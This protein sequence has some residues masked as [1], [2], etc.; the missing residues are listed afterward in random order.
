[1]S[2][3]LRIR[4]RGQN[5]GIPVDPKPGGT[6]Y[7]TQ[8]EV[9]V[10]RLFHVREAQAPEEAVFGQENPQEGRPEEKDATGQE[11]KD[12]KAKKKEIARRVR[13]TA[14]DALPGEATVREGAF[15]VSI[16][17]SRCK[18]ALDLLGC[19][20]WAS[21]SPVRP[22]VFERCNPYIHGM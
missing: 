17:L 14:P 13:T 19:P 10:G 4:G 18:K 16:L 11:G 5:T 8:E 9:H 7:D 15:F 21:R 12:L 20:G 22:S 3:T 2:I 6:E 1:M